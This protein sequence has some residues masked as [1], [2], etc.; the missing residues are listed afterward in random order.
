[1]WCWSADSQQRRLAFAALSDVQAQ[2]WC[3][4]GWGQRDL[5]AGNSKRTRRLFWAMWRKQVTLSSFGHIDHMTWAWR[6][7][8]TLIS[9]LAVKTEKRATCPLRSVSSEIS[10]RGRLG[11][12]PVA[13][14]TTKPTMHY[15][16]STLSCW[17]ESLTFPQMGVCTVNRLISK[18]QRG[19]P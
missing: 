15:W 5:K 3:V 9:A 18:Q 6:P 1:M 7:S 8:V 2:M 14:S 10:T 11:S 12:Q 4:G 19:I 17:N 13:G 16:F